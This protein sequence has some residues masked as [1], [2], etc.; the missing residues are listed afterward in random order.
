[1][2]IDD[3]LSRL[4]GVKPCGG[5]WSA[6][7]PNHEDRHSSLTIGNGSDGKILVKCHAGCEV[8]AIVSRMGLVMSDLFSG[9]RQ[10]THV[11][12]KQII[13]RYPYLD[14]KGKLIYEVVRFYPKDFRIRRPD[15][16]GGW[17]WN[18][19]GVRRILYCLP[20][21]LKAEKV[22]IVEGEKDA[23]ALRNLGQAATTNPGGAGKWSSEYSECCPG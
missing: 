23:E 8:E 6:H 19:E 15:G 7:C 21:V 1:M 22:Y 11:A 3:F 5:G 4:E 16:Q 14:E 17:I 12:E 13:T 2:K 18:L 10:D 20:E 9:A